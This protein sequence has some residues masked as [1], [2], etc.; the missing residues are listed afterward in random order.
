MNNPLRNYASLVAGLG[1]QHAFTKRRNPPF[2]Y[3]INM[4]LEAGMQ[5]AIVFTQSL[6]SFGRKRREK[7]SSKCVMT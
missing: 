2:N 5:I 7:E 1:A 3:A 4:Q 6:A